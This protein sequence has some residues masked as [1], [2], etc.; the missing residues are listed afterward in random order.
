MAITTRRVTGPIVLPDG[1]VPANGRVIVA[2][3]GWDRE[4][5][6]GVMAGPV[7]IALDEGG[8]FDADLWCTDTGEN[9]RVYTGLIRWFTGAEWRS[10]NIQFDVPSGAGDLAFAPIWVAGDLPPSTQADALA[11]CLAA[12]AQT[13]LDRVATGEDAVAA[14]ASASA[15]A[16][17][18][19]QL[20]KSTFAATRAPLPTD[21]VSQG[22]G[23]GSRW[24]WQ[25][26]EW[27][28][29]ASTPGA[30]VWQRSDSLSLQGFGARGDGSD[31]SAAVTAA[32]NAWAAAQGDL[33]V[34]PGT[35]VKDG[36][37]FIVPHVS[38]LTRGAPSIPVNALS[39][40]RT[41][42]QLY[43]IETEDA[44][45][46]DPALSKVGL[47]VTARGYG[48]QHIDGIRTN[49]INRST[50]G[51]GNCAIYTHAQSFTGTGWTTALHGETYHGGGTSIGLN[52][53]MS[54]SSAAG[55][56]YGAVLNIP[57]R[58][59]PDGSPG[60]LHP[61][62]TAMFVQ[63]KN[64]VNPIGAWAFGIEI[65]LDAMRSDGTSIRLRDDVLKH[66][67]VM[68]SA[69]ASFAD[70]HLQANSAIGI[71]LDG[72]Y[73]GAAISLKSGQAIA[74]ETTN[75]ITVAYGNNPNVLG[76]SNAGTERVGF[77]M[78]ASPAVRMN[79]V[80]VLG[81]RRTGWSL[82]S[83]TTSRGT[84]DT[85]TVTVV[86]LARRLKGL[87]E[88]LHIVSGGHGLIGNT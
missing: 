47:S 72:T 48:G 1:S 41:T 40:A 3:S 84:F 31:D 75:A 60:I 35:Y 86:E 19:A 34:P 53:E 12:A 7:T 62:A 85:E 18:A 30:A 17:A 50:D 13:A 77:T 82:P 76:F 9:G 37:S 4:D 29:T 56:F 22:Y 39:S 61:N 21:D 65:G 78:T 38:R 11:Q 83:G 2:L 15:A 49:L 10:Q 79:G 87:I 23:V 42:L 16:T 43:T 68:A 88:D 59:H 58:P 28:M 36:V 27:T 74:F 44:P 26:Q 69:P 20:P 55:S 46:L 64:S 24:L 71:R 81:P 8:V 70:I 52:V 54:S 66:L 45:V 63:G 14:A 80:V 25:G 67:H 5:G 6:Q 73:T 51:N 57:Y 33:I 32:Q